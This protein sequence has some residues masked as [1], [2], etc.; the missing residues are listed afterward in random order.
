MLVPVEK[1]SS[2][3]LI[4][5]ALVPLLVSKVIFPAELLV[6]GANVIAPFR[7]MRL[8]EVNVISEP[9]APLI[10]PD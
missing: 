9:L 3:V 1:L 4:L 2:A 6:L 8:L 10:A 7:S 5:D